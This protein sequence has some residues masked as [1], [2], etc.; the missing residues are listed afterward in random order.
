VL[1]KEGNILATGEP[2]QNPIKAP[3][4]ALYNRSNFNFLK[5]MFVLNFG[6][7]RLHPDGGPHLQ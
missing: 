4:E 7:Y 5:F 3:A 2:A 1:G 6:G